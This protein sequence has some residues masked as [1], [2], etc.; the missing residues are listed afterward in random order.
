MICGRG[1]RRTCIADAA[2]TVS[3]VIRGPITRASLPGLSERC[4]GF[5]ARNAGSVVECEVVGVEPDAVTV[6]ALARLQLVAQH[7]RCRVVL[8]GASNDL[9]DLVEFMGLGDVLT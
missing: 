5:F 1:R 6:D 4:C 7:N 9:V 2:G 3:L 8:V